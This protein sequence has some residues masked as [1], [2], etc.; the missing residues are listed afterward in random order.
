MKLEDVLLSE[1][2]QAQKGINRI[3]LKGRFLEESDSQRQKLEWWLPGAGEVRGG[4]PDIYS[5]YHCCS[6]SDV[7]FLRF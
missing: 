3:P 5:L 7:P 6:V 2:S 4:G 1:I